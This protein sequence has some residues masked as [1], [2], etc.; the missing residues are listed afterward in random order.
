MLNKVARE[1]RDGIVTA[2]V[3]N[4]NLKTML[5]LL[6]RQNEWSKKRVLEVTVDAFEVVIL[7]LQNDK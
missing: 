7:I 2:Y 4:S 1:G 3:S 5:M 6:L